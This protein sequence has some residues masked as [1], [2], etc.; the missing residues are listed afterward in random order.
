MAIVRGSISRA[1]VNYP[2]LD[3]TSTR[4]IGWGAG[5]W[6]TDYYQYFNI[7]IEY[8][9][10]PRIGTQG[11]SIHGISVKPPDV[12]LTES[13]DDILIVVMAAHS[14]EIMQQ[15]SRDYGNFRVV[16]AWNFSPDTVE[17]DEVC[18]LNSALSGIS[19]AKRSAEIERLG[20][21]TQGPIFDCTP[22]ALARNRLQYPTAY[23][24]FVTW[25]HQPKHLIEKCAPW[26]DRII[27]LPQP[28]NLGMGHRNAM[29]RSAR[30]GAEC[31]AQ[32]GVRYAVR[33]RS[34]AVI[35][36]SVGKAIWRMF[37]DG[38]KN[39]G[40][41]GI[42][43]GASW[44]HMPFMFSDMY[45]IARTEDMLELW[46][47]A[48]YLRTSA[49]VPVLQSDH[50]LE[51]RKVTT[52]SMLWSNFAAKRGFATNDLSDSYRFAHS[53]LLPL[54][55]DVSMLS[56]K[57]MPLFNLKLDRGYSPDKDWWANMQSDIEG[58][59]EHAK[60]ISELNMT[61]GD[62]WQAKIG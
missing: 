42:Y 30:A 13:R 12:L 51:L 15:I 5:Q 52:E 50:F 28:E 54:E 44:K 8:T 45:M 11:V 25:D 48:E 46:S 9:I 31:M 33:C 53:N 35:T 19:F 7:P 1:L 37:G 10:C 14:P 6:F 43:L 56:L 40:K 55:P 4:L 57:H 38:Q 22:L 3:I 29:L 21:F 39:I 62:F 59:V 41:V 27:T 20:I 61:V 2:D 60:A 32:R 16:T 47:L 17:I 23:H 24:C 26:V 36:G 18:E 49:D 58:A 34:N